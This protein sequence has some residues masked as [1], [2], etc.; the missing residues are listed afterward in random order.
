ME[1]IYDEDLTCPTYKLSKLETEELEKTGFVQ[2]D[3]NGIVITKID[4]QYTVALI[5]KEKNV[6]EL[7]Y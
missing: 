1:V 6:I 5:E 7:K 4:K 2:D 3:K